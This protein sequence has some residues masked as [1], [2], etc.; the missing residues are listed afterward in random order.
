[1]GLSNYLSLP[2][3]LQCNLD[4]IFSYKTIWPMA[5]LPLSMSFIFRLLIFSTTMTLIFRLFYD[6]TDIL[7]FALGGV[8]YRPSSRERLLGLIVTSLVIV[9]HL[10]R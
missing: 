10:G 6:H 3:S 7:R 2:R 5:V 8:T 4:R 1:M 9:R